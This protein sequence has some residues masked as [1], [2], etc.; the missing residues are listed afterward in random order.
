MKNIQFHPDIEQ[1]TD[2]W[3][4]ARCGLWTASRVGALKKKGTAWTASATTA[5]E[6]L[7]AERI[8]GKCTEHYVT[9]AMQHGMDLEPDA[10]QA[11]MEISGNVVEPGGWWTAETDAGTPVGCSPDGLIDEDGLLEIKCPFNINKHINTCITNELPAEY[12]AQV[13]LQ[14]LVTGRK[15]CDFVSYAPGVTRCPCVVI[16][17]RCHPGN[18]EAMIDEAE[19]AVRERVS[20]FESSAQETNNENIRI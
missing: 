10:R 12:L 7:S 4:R 8:I 5:I 18:L 20:L 2:V 14:M 1:R 6:E 19:S 3:M 11:Y 15:W 9:A 13:T 17:T 16:G